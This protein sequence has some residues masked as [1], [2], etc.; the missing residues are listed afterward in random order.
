MPNDAK[1]GLVA[2]MAAVVLIAVFFFRKDNAPGQPSAPPAQSALPDLPP[3]LPRSAPP[4]DH[5]NPPLPPPPALPESPM[6]GAE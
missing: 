6:N 2:G 1:L 4:T 5:S 3:V